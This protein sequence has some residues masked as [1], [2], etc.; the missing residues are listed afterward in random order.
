[1]DN[2]SFISNNFNYEIVYESDGVLR[3]NQIE[4]DEIT[5]LYKSYVLTDL[6]ISIKNKLI[7][8]YFYIEYRSKNS[9]NE[10]TTVIVPSKSLNEVYVSDGMVFTAWTQ[11]FA[12]FISPVLA[13]NICEKMGL[14]KQYNMSTFL[15]QLGSLS[16]QLNYD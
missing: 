4:I 12:P 10:Y 1:M 3:V 5:G 8:T 7:V 11:A 6:K 16:N 9:N 14:P 15:T 13:N 2:K